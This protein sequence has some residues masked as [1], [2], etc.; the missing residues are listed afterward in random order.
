MPKKEPVAG[1]PKIDSA[2]DISKLPSVNF[3]FRRLSL[4]MDTES[5]E[6]KLNSSAAN[7]H[8]DTLIHSLNVPPKVE[9]TKAPDERLPPP[10]SANYLGL[11]PMQIKK[12][13]ERNE[14]LAKNHFK[15]GVVALPG[16]PATVK[17]QHKEH[18]TFTA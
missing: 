13:R 18:E 4:A 5:L 16:T 8:G 17:S 12:I 9:E 6:K 7:P 1:F 15:S 10:Q 2:N 3:V 11:D 14:F